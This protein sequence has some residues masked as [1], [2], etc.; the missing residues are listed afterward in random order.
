MINPVDLSISEAAA[1][2]RDG[3]V[4]A[5][6]LAQAALDRIAR[7]DRHIHAFVAMNRDQVMQEA[8]RADAALAQGRN[9]GLL[10]GIPIAVKDLIDVAGLPCTSGSAAQKGRMPHRDAEA[11]R[12]M[13]AAGAV[14]LGK[15]ATYEFAM[16]GPDF[17][18]PDP[19]ARNPWNAARIT[20]GSSSG[21]AAAVAAGIVRASLSTDSGGSIRSP[22]SYCGVVGLKPTFGRV[23]RTGVYPLS[24]TLDHVGPIAATV[25]EAALVLDALTGQDEA[26][27]ASVGQSWRPATGLI[28]RDLRNLR[29]GYARSWFSNDSQTEP[30]LITAMDAAVSQLSLLG[31]RVE[32]I[33]P[34]SYFLFE[35]ASSVILHAE[36]LAVH[37]ERLR[38]NCAFYGAPVLQS[39]AAGA[40]IDPGDVEK[41]RRAARLLSQGLGISMTGFDALITT[42][43]LTVAPPFSAFDGEKAAWTPMRTIPFNLTGNP[44][45]SVPIGFHAGLPYG[46]Q[47][48]GVA[49]A[50][51]VICRIG[52]AFERATDHSVQHPAFAG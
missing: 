50:E 20:G 24:P 44:A 32:E 1:R 42:T 41:A 29:I 47:I 15:L 21:S 46:M 19:P 22:A 45:L 18:L 52:H 9:F 37:R 23:P 31:A 27:A 51:D 14:I 48:V 25:E 49:G 39:L 36:A 10:H 7:R 16:A 33:D 40:A 4:T 13:R 12:L 26:D 43:T 5:V 35:A 38:T 30:A 6:E 28:G 3:Q 17:A 34:P 11:V 8:M 2:L